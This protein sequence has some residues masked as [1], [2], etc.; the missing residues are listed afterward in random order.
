MISFLGND[1]AEKFAKRFINSSCDT[2][3]YLLPL[4][5][6]FQ[7]ES[8]V[9]VDD[10]DLHGMIS[11]IPA[12]GNPNKIN[13]TKLLFKNDYYDTGKQLI[14]FVLA[15]YGAK[16]AQTF[17]VIVDESHDELAKLFIEG[18]GFRKCACELLWRVNNFDF[19][20]EEF[21]GFRQ[22]KNSDAQSVAMLFND[23]LITHFKPS[24]LKNKNEYNDTIFKGLLNDTE[25]K[26]VLEDVNLHTI[27]A[28]FSVK[29]YDNYNY[30]LDITSS[31]GFTLNYDDV[32]G[33]VKTEILKRQK[34]FSLFVKTKQY[35]QNA[36]NLDEYLIQK[37]FKC[38]Q[39][40]I[41]LVKDFY[42]L[43]KQENTASNVV[44]FAESGRPVFKTITQK[45]CD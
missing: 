12:K 45:N 18:C 31:T 8:Y 19:G 22:F 38:V 25:F 33:F 16:G 1:E 35:T 15:R 2:F 14:E 43:I 10:N 42:K 5:M 27:L 21:C 4:S 41:V 23:S 28:F 7:E 9:L 6:K 34:D 17:M 36:K 11:V 20:A 29:T 24:L 37:D 13:I 3:H 44:L 26:Y 39:N 30:I 40:Q 32:L